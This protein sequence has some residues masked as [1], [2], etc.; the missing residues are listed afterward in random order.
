MSWYIGA[1]NR[2]HGAASNRLKIV[3]L[4]STENSVQLNNNTFT[5]QL[6][7]AAGTQ[8]IL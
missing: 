4:T 2:Y 5:Q 1:H 8:V 3:K 6:G 7:R